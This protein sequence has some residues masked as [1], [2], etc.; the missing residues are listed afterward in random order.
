PVAGFTGTLEE[1][2]G[3]EQNKP[4]AG[5]VRAKTGT[6]TGINTLAGTVVDADGRLLAFA[7]MTSGTKD[8]EGAK[9]ALDRMAS[10]LANCG[11]RDS[12]SSG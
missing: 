3:D 11:C 10:A 9:N 2:Y 7:F 8:A 12:P 4:G 6:L 1:R 5:L